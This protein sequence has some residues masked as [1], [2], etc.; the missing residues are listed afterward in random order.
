MEIPALLA[1][2]L[3]TATVE[4]FEMMIG[5]NIEP[6]PKG[7]EPPAHWSSHVAASVAFGGHRNGVVCIH[8][9][10]DAAKEIAGA[11]LG[12]DPSEINGEMSD[13]MG[14]V[15]NLVAGSFRTKLAAVE[16]ASVITVPS[17]TVGSDFST[18]YASNAAREIYPFAMG[19][20]SLLVEL[21]LMER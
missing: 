9:S 18:R 16:P 3:V 19:S 10:A 12:I 21:I 13:A 1:T 5:C 20:E 15:A 8:S 11:M 7:P 14:E 17:V 4:A 2:H 6:R